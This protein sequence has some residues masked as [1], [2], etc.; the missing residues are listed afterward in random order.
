MQNSEDRNANQS[1]QGPGTIDRLRSLNCKVPTAALRR[2]KVAAA[3]SGLPFKEY[4]ARLLMT[5][6]PISSTM[7]EAPPELAVRVADGI[8]REQKDST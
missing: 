2:A 7:E 3:E 6:K 5:A 1:K 8:A 4:M